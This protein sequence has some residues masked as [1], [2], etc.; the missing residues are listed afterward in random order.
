[1]YF[2]DRLYA[3]EELPE[4]LL[5]DISAEDQATRGRDA[6]ETAEMSSQV[7]SQVSGR[8]GPGEAL[9]TPRTDTE[10]PTE[11]ITG[12]KH[13]REFYTILDSV[14]EEPLELWQKE[15]SL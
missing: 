7:S 6:V 9:S 2:S 3:N 1:M 8:Q 4:D 11:Q 14:E 15:V 13:K 12:P 5:T 10:S